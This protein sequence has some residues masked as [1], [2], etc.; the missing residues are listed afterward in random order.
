MP[1]CQKHFWNELF[2]WIACKT[3]NPKPCP[4]IGHVKNYSNSCMVIISFIYQYVYFGFKSW[5]ESDVDCM[6]SIFFIKV[7][8]VWSEVILSASTVVTLK[9]YIKSFCVRTRGIIKILRH[10]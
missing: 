7:E 6:A 5:E 8:K 10:K 9:K 3:V 1:N 2:H 4:L